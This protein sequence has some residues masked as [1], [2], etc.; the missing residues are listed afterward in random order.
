MPKKWTL[1]FGQPFKCN[2][3]THATAWSYCDRPHHALF[4][5]LLRRLP[6]QALVPAFTI[7]EPEVVANSQPVFS[8]CF[9]CLEVHIF[10]FQAAPQA[11]RKHIV[12]GLF[13][14]IGRKNHLAQ[15]RELLVKDKTGELVDAEVNAGDTADSGNRDASANYVCPDCGAAM[16]I[17]EAFWRG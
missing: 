1:I 12:Y 6:I 13:A 3:P 4:I 11:F 7:V 8:D 10:V 14:N 16:I 9:L 15:I 2:L 5:D 17:I